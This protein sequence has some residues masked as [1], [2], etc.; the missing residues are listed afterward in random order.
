MPLYFDIRHPRVNVEM[1]GYIPLFLSVNDPRPARQQFAQNYAHGGGWDPMPG[2]D[3]LPNGN[4]KYKAD[5]DSLPIWAEAR[6]RDEIIRVYESDWVAIIQP[7]GS[8][9]VCRMD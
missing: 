2:W 1:L 3:L 6:L 5:R 7:D 4:L 9:E 8:F